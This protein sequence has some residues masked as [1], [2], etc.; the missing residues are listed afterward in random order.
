MNSEHTEFIMM[1][2]KEKPI[3][4]LLNFNVICIPFYSPNYM[5]YIQIF[6]R[7]ENQNTMYMTKYQTKECL[8]K[9][10]EIS[11][12]IQHYCN[13]FHHTLNQWATVDT[14]QIAPIHPPKKKMNILHLYLNENK[15]HK[16]NE[17]CE[18]QLSF[19]IY[20]TFS[21]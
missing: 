3:R 12:L 19:N 18:V 14:S 9:I 21:I 1:K 4:Q 2:W 15:T 16:N 11:V 7:I 6:I 5:V 13:F 8:M 20:N 17:N 10:G